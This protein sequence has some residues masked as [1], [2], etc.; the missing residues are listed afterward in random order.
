MI[1]VLEHSRYTTRL[2]AGL[3]V[4]KFKMYSDNGKTNAPFPHNSP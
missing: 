1:G 3:A 4:K 2:S